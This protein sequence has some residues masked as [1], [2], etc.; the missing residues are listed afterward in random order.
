MSPP[1]LPP[2]TFRVNTENFKSPSTKCN[3]YNYVTILD[4]VF[5][6][7]SWN[8]NYFSVPSMNN[9]FRIRLQP[10]TTQSSIVNEKFFYQVIVNAK[11]KFWIL[12]HRMNI[13]P[14]EM[15]SS[16]KIFVQHFYDQR[17]LLTPP[18]PRLKRP[19]SSKL[20]FKPFII[21]NTKPLFGVFTP[22]LDKSSI[23]SWPRSRC[24]DGHFR[25]DA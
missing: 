5:S 7:W 25:N 24:S 2:R 23:W 15:L 1:V 16:I 20:L 10:S 13:Q 17:K 21:K 14:N 11:H 18:P 6:C 12:I 4:L 8:I 22:R 3:F 9:E 19:F